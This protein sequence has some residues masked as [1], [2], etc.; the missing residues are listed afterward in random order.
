MASIGTLSTPDAQNL[1]RSP[2]E[3]QKGFVATKNHSQGGE[4]VK[5]GQRK[6]RCHLKPRNVA[7]LKCQLLQY[8]V[9]CLEKLTH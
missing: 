6:K 2:M 1:N 3:T 8:V 9:I 7:K 5:T 4:K